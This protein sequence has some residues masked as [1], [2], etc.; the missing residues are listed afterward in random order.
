MLHRV[1][2]MFCFWLPRH[3]PDETM[4]PAKR[5]IVI[6]FIMLW[7]VLAIPSVTVSTLQIIEVLLKHFSSTPKISQ[8]MRGAMVPLLILEL[9]YLW[10]VNTRALLVADGVCGVFAMLN[11]LSFLYILLSP[12]NPTLWSLAR[13]LLLLIGNVAMILHITRHSFLDRSAVIAQEIKVAE[14]NNRLLKEQ[15]NKAWEIRKRQNM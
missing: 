9:V 5:S 2:Q 8:I 3:F 4:S 12:T 1:R 11:I 7:M 10:K 15:L 14:A 13:P 6:Y